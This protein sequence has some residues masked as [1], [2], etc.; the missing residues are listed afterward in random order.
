M[1]VAVLAYHS[2][3]LIEPGSGDAGG[4]TVYVR[5]VARV[6]AKLGIRTDVFTRS[7]SG[8]LEATDIFPTVR[9]VAIPAGPSG[10]VPKSDLTS[11]VS[12][13]VE[14]VAGFAASEGLDY[15]LI[16]SHY[17]QSGIVG[18]QLAERWDVP[19]VHSNHTLARVKNRHLPPGETPEP[20][21]RLDG[22]ADVISVADT[23]IASTDEEWSDLACLYRASHDRIKRVYPGVDHSLFSPGSKS[24]ARAE[25][26]LGDEAVLACVGRVQPLKG[27]DLALRAVE[28]LVPVLD[29]PV[30]LL[31]VGGASGPSG[32]NEAKRL[33]ALAADLGIQDA[34]RFEGPQPHDLTPTYYRAADALLVCSFSESF[35]LS[36]LEAQACGT[37]V[38]GTDVGGLRHIV[39][40]DLGGF[41]VE[42]REPSELAGRLKTLL[43]DAD[44]HRRSSAAATASSARFTWDRTAREL[45]DLY[46]C[47]ITETLPELCTC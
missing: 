13:F 36:A 6:M 11:Y 40:D 2:S 5:E 44:L 29:R 30:K 43:S 18:K 35:G 1:R 17:W 24:A 26:G 10:D 3:P 16:H 15:E 31:V 32:E 20:R 47:L 14:G 12:D 4:M 23:L 38:V 37:P 9:V 25:L 27:L 33:D 22:E 19:L 8:R 42:T 7:I 45:G 46:E 28:Q 21:A 39:G 41:L 34:I